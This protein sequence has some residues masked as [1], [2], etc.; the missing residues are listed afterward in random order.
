MFS[1]K[2]KNKAKKTQKTN[3]FILND[4]ITNL[5]LRNEFITLKS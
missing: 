3:E 4:R 5:S 2:K 1:V